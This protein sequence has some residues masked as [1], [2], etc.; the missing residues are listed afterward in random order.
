MGQ[1]ILRTTKAVRLA[2]GYTASTAEPWHLIF[3]EGL[4]TNSARGGRLW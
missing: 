1:N 2:L 4:E 3:W